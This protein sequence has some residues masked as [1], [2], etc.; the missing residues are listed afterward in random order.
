MGSGTRHRAISARGQLACVIPHADRCR[1]GGAHGATEPHGRLVV[2]FGG[3]RSTGPGAARA[4]ARPT[5]AKRRCAWPA[6][7]ETARAGTRVEKRASE[8]G[9]KDARALMANARRR[10]RAAGEVR[11]K[12]L[13]RATC[14]RQAGAV[15][16]NAPFLSITKRRLCASGRPMEGDFFCQDKPGCGPEGRFISRA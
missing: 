6:R 16:A 11:L 12:W 9:R 13:C 5:T 1:K 14:D 2:V 10:P 4:R 7:A 3:C 8:L 15:L